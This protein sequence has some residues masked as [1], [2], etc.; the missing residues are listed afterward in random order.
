MDKNIFRKKSIERISSPEQLGDYIKVSNPSIWIILAA[1]IV[2]LAGACV[3]GIFG[4]IETRISVPV[5]AENGSITAY[6]D[7]EQA[8][9]V[10]DGMEI[11][12]DD[13][14]F[15]ITGISSKPIQIDDSFDSYAMHI[16]GF[17]DGQWVYEATAQS[18]IAEGT[19]EAS[20]VTES[21]S[22]MS[23]VFN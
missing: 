7:E 5:V 9:T 10:G 1:V 16:G 11:T 13:K 2:L 17:Q 4:T 22:P 14:E 19:Y 6:L 12:I 8:G 15:K 20:I 18:D 21:I 23:F 3:W